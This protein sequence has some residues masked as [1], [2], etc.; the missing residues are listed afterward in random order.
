MRVIP[1]PLYERSYRGKDDSPLDISKNIVINFWQEIDEMIYFVSLVAPL[2]LTVLGGGVR[3][4]LSEC[5][6]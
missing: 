1:A 4:S 5:A 6:C 3:D 2:H